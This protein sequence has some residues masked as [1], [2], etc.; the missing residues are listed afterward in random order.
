MATVRKLGIWMD[1][2]KAF[3]IENEN[4]KQIESR[5]EHFNLHGGAKGKT[6]YGT[7]DATSETK[8]LERNKHQLKNYFDQIIEHAAH[9]DKIVVF[10]PAEA[11]IAFQKEIETN[12]S[13]KEK[14]QGVETVDNKFT[15]N[16]L[17]EWV[18]NYYSNK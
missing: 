14:L 15:E 8:L 13:I 9:A 6:P 11:K 4:I 2:D 18:R 17:I 3:I 16:Q 7:Q 12:T 10:G 1:S 5:V